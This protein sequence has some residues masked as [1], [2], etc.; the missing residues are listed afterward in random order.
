[1][2]NAKTPRPPR[3]ETP[4]KR[5]PSNMIGTKEYSWRSYL[6]G[7]GV[8]AFI[9]FAS[10]SARPEVPA[11]DDFYTL[12][13]IPDTQYYTEVQWKTDQHFKGQT[14]W[15]LHHRANEHTALAFHPG[16]LH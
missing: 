13:V 15:L 11:A 14:Q 12:V 7:L 3:K 2:L 6:G 4:R 9:L 5:K 10:F 16:H 1:M 8:L